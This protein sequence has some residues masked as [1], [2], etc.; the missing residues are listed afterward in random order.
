MA[1]K[2]NICDRCGEV[3]EAYHFLDRC[4]KLELVR[5][6]KEIK[7]LKESVLSWKDSWFHLR[8]I[9]GNLWWH[10]PAIDDDAQRAYY[11]AA[12]KRCKEKS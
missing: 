9:I 4:E 12:Q 6:K 2:I 5:A 8:E 1:E 3:I 11:Q 7:T 10:H